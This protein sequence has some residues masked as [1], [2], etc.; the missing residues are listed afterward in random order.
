MLEGCDDPASWDGTNITASADP[1]VIT[2]GVAGDSVRFDLKFN[3]SDRW[4]YPFFKIKDSSVLKNTTG[5]CFWVY[6]EED[7]RNISMNFFAYLKDGRQFY[8]GHSK[9]KQ[10]KKGWNQVT[11]PWS[12]L[13]LQ[14]SPYGLLDFRPFDTDLIT[15]ISVGCNS[16]YDDVAPYEI[17]KLGYYVE[18]AKDTSKS[19]IKVSGIEEGVHYNKSEL[20]NVTAQLPNQE[21]KDVT[22]TV[23]EKKFDNITIENNNISMDLSSLERGCYVVRI[24]AKTQF[25]FMLRKVVNIYVE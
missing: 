1:A 3:G 14:Y 9:G 7:L 20:T 5:I 12:K 18:E 22:V 10:I 17:A 4:F 15:K 24:V 19:E 11:V 8:L 23:N 21:Y 13:S 6:A 2:K 16:P 25:N